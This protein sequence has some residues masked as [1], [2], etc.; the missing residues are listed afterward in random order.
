MKWLLEEV[1][2]LPKLEDMLVG[3]SL[4]DENKLPPFLQLYTG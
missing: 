2:T 1:I 4:K 3:L